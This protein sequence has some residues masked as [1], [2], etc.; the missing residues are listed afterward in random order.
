VVDR[1]YRILSKRDYRTEVAAG[2]K[3]RL[4]ASDDAGTNDRRRQVWLAARIRTQL[5]PLDDDCEGDR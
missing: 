5:A 2:Y 1:F 4:P 3:L